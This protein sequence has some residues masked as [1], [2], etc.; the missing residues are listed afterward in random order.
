MVADLRIVFCIYKAVI[1]I[2][3]SIEFLNCIIILIQLVLY[4]L[5]PVIR[6]P[7]VKIRLIIC[8]RKKYFNRLTDCIKYSIL[9]KFI[10]QS[11]I[12]NN[13][14]FIQR[15]SCFYIIFTLIHKINVYNISYKLAIL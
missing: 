8:V 10:I 12:I 6:I 2:T 5:L 13:F 11:K 3:V 7:L 1:K 15:I 4:S 14:F 9:S